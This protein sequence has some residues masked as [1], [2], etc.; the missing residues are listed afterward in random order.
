MITQIVVLAGGLATRLYPITTTIPKSMVSVAGEPF[1]A[2]Q[3]R[4]F[5]RQGITD[6]VMCVGHFADQIID[7]FGDGHDLGVSITYSVEEKKLD[8]GGA[9]KLA[10]PYLDEVFFTIYG[11]SYLRQSYA[12]VSEFFFSNPSEGLMCVYENN[13]QIEPSRVLLDGTLVKQYKKDPPPKGAQHMEYGLNI[14]KR[15]LIPNVDKECF[16]ISDYFD[17]LTVQHQLL[18]FPVNERFYEIGSK[19]GLAETDA[20]MSSLPT[21]PS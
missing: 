9:L 20:L 17:M 1:L 19:E 18:A 11:D 14:F 7:H 15:T 3:L 6:V 21:N 10:Y 13:N 2:H 8:T 16:P 12:P 4:T 5:H